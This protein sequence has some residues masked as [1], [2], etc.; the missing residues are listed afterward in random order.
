MVI[1]SHARDAIIERIGA[2][3]EKHIKLAWKAWCSAEPVYDAEISNPKFYWEKYDAQDCVQVT[4][5]LMGRLFV[6]VKRRGTMDRLV[7]ITVCPAHQRKW[8][9]SKLSK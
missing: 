3:P 4:K 8:T 5:K 7:L 2:K 6:F 1:T 9:K